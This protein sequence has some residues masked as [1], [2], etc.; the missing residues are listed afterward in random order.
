LTLRWFTW[1]WGWIGVAL[2]VVGLLVALWSQNRRWNRTWYVIAVAGPLFALYVL[3][4][5]IVP[6]QPW[7]MRRFYATALILIPLFQAIAF[8]WMARSVDAS[9][10]LSRSLR[11]LAL[12]VVALVAVIVPVAVSAPLLRVG[13]QAGLRES[14]VKMCAVMPENSAVV[15]HGESIQ[16]LG[17]AV[18]S[19]CDIPTVASVSDLG[20]LEVGTLATDLTADG[21]HVIVLITPTATIPTGWRIIASETKDIPFAEVVLF[22]PSAGAITVEFSWFAS[23]PDPG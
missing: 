14:V 10:G 5:S 1:Y 20:L 11:R 7:A 21:E 8:D 2:A 23:I 18:R 13:P 16:N 3:R 22:R 9:A 6:D 19:F 17:A 15:F 12:I 4:P